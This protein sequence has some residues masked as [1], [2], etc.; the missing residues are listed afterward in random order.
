M[1]GLLLTPF[2]FFRRKRLGLKTG[3]QKQNYLFHLWRTHPREKCLNLRA[4]VYAPFVRVR[5][6]ILTKFYLVVR[7]YLISLSF[8]FRKDWCIRL[9]DIQLLVTMYI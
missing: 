5:A 3:S 4:R 6:Q 7:K 8:K 1:F 9:G 2:P